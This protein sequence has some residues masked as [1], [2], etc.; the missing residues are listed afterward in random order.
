MYQDER[1]ERS[2]NRYGAS[3]GGQKEARRN[4]SDFKGFAHG[5]GLLNSTD[6]D[7]AKMVFQTVHFVI[8][9]AS[10]VFN[11]LKHCNYAI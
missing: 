3:F 4:I 11:L 5:R 8:Q 10:V 7:I 2:H 1:R 6:P 9:K